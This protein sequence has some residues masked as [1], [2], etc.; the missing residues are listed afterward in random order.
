MG[1]C[2]IISFRTAEHECGSPF[3]PI[4]EILEYLRGRLCEMNAQATMWPGYEKVFPRDSQEKRKTK[5]GLI[6]QTPRIGEE[7]LSFARILL[8]QEPWKEEREK[9]EGAPYTFTNKNVAVFLHQ[10]QRFLEE[11]A[12]TREG[13]LRFCGEWTIRFAEAREVY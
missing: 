5:D 11:T 3:F 6:S 10:Y 7:S 1:I 13:I 4:E 9:G 8:R 12:E 2:V